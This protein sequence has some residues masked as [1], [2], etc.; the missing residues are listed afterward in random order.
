MTDRP[1]HDRYAIDPNRIH[2]ELGWQ[3]SIN[4][5]NNL[6]KTVKWYL[7]NRNWCAIVKLAA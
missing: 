5:E 1:G 6:E 7:D 3:P 4:F 2:K